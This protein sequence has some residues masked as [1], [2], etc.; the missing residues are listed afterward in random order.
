MIETRHGDPREE[1]RIKIPDACEEGASID[2][3][4]SIP[5]RLKTVEEQDLLVEMMLYCPERDLALVL[6]DSAKAIW[7]LCDGKRTIAEINQ[8]IGDRLNCSDID[9]LSVLLSDVRATIIQLYHLSFL[10]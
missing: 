7:E 9:L 8:E 2:V 5:C 1:L 4:N 6:N 10:E 3:A